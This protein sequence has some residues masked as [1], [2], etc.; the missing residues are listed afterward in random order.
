M[1]A[2][3]QPELSIVVLCYRSEEHIIPFVDELVELAEKLTDRWEVVLV[4]NYIPGTADRTQDIVRE[5]AARDPRLRTVIEP[6]RGMMGWDMRKGMSATVGEY[7]CVIDGDG[8]FPIESIERCVEAIKRGGLDLVKTHR[9]ERHDGRYRICISRVYNALFK[10]LFPGLSCRDVNSKP[11][12]LRRQAYERMGLDSDGWLIDAEIMI[13][14][15]R[16]GMSFEELPIVFSAINSRDSFVKF[17]A[18]FEFTRELLRYRIR[19]FGIRRPDAR[20]GS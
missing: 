12:I 8:Q 11:K 15:R 13:N 20:D 16:F 1:V 18:L 14:V 4:G 6:K 9:V 5:L 2:D 19:E 10:L 17:G 7:I 3:L